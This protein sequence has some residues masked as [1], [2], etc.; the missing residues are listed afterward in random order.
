MKSERLTVI[1]AMILVSGI[2]AGCRAASPVKAKTPEDKLE[3]LAKCLSKKGAKL[4]VTHRCGWCAR[5]K[6]VFGEAARHLT[7]IECA[8]KK[9]RRITPRCRAAGIRGFPTWIIEGKKSPGFKS[10]EK[11]AGLSGCPF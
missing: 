8:D 1:L 7:Y 4:Y 3:T 9:T 10:P 6:K 5:Q 2:M 11:L